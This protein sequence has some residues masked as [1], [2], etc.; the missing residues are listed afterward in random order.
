[1]CPRS[2]ARSIRGFTAVEMITIVAILVILMTMTIAALRP[3]L[4][5]S[6]VNEA[7][8]A[9]LSL[10]RQAVSVA[11]MYEMAGG[12]AGAISITSTTTN[13]IITPKI[14]LAGV[15]FSVGK[16]LSPNITLA[17]ESFDPTALTPTYTT[18]TDFTY[19]SKT[20]FLTTPASPSAIR[21]TAS[22]IDGSKVSRA[23]IYHTGVTRNLPSK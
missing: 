21:I 1:M 16:S 19:E 2:L 14:Q 18:I 3:A 11:R 6:T 8:E 23:V 13:G 17:L 15:D 12:T 4:Q 20:G 9:L 7:N 10:H 22:T 5:R